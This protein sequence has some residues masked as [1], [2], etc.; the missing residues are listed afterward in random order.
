MRGS[1]DLGPGGACG[2]VSGGFRGNADSGQGGAFAAGREQDETGDDRQD[3]SHG[4]AHRGT[5]WV[6]RRRAGACRDAAADMPRGGSPAAPGTMPKS[7][8]R[9]PR[10]GRSEEHTSELQSLM[11]ISYAVFFLKK[12]IIRLLLP[13][14]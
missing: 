1:S 11:R 9:H 7:S 13:N 8:R 14:P 10:A 3:A 6:I 2:V 5:A 4:G 12:K